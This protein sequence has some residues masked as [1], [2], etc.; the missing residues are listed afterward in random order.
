MDLP[1]K[2]GFESK[3]TGELVAGEVRK[4]A[5]LDLFAWT[6][7]S[8]GDRD[9]DRSWNWRAIYLDQKNALDEYECYAA[10]VGNDLHGLMALNIGRQASDQKGILV[11]YLATKPENRLPGTGLRYVGTAL[12]AVALLRSI[13]SGKN[14]KVWLESLPGAQAFYESLGMESEGE[15]SEDGNVIYRIEPEGA[16]R[17]LDKIAKKGILKL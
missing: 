10:V 4:T 1:I 7:W 6:S 2:V 16:K 5:Y 14:G 15:K 8:Y 9:E 12:V 11:D 3:Q 13:E 17:L